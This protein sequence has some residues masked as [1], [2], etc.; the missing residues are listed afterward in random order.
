MKT[1]VVQGAMRSE[2]EILISRFPGG[3]FADV[4]GYSFYEAALD[5][6]TVV[7]S[8]TEMGTINATVATMLAIE[9]YKPDVI[10]NQGT[11]GAH[12]RELCVGDIIIG[13]EAVYIN[14]IRTPARG[15]GEGSN[16][17][18]WVPGRDS[19]LTAADAKLVDKALAIPYNG[20]KLLCGRLGTGDVFSK[21]VDRIDLLHSQLGHMCED[22]ESV[23]VY[24]ACE[25]M[26]VP[27]IGIRV[28]SN[29][30]L[31]GNGD[32]K[33]QF[34]IAQSLLQDFIFDYIADLT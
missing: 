17:L 15:A 19:F 21:E 10:I 28:I 14:N 26:G 18:D 32:V 4:R 24:R 31:V 1:I 12:L 20:G 29:N 33:K 34:D 3:K 16:A 25:I 2:V 11:A 8:R 5:G 27:V 9:K 6:C 23:A 30:E 7:I 22:M 13:R